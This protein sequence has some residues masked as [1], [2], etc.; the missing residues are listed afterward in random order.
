[1]FISVGFC[2]PSE[3]GIAEGAIVFQGLCSES[4]KLDSKGVPPFQGCL[5]DPFL[6]ECANC[7]A[8]TDPDFFISF[9]LFIIP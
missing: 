4:R 7:I 6:P 2:Q 9:G 1:M 3:S 8:G 5:A